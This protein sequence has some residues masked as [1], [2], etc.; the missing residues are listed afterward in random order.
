MNQHKPN[1]AALTMLLMSDPPQRAKC[2]CGAN[3]QWGKHQAAYEAAMD[4]VVK[5]GEKLKENGA[6]TMSHY[7]EA[8]YYMALGLAKMGGSD[9]PPLTIVDG[10]IWKLPDGEFRVWANYGWQTFIKP[11]PMEAEHLPTYIS[12]D[13]VK[14]AEG[15]ESGGG[16][17]GGGAQPEQEPVA[18]ITP[19][20]EGFRMRLEPPTDDVPMGWKALYTA[21]P[22]RDWVGLTDDEVDALGYKYGAGGLELLKEIETKLKEKNK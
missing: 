21:Q 4:H 19:D 17:G 8:S 20:G 10:Q 13:N 15:T 3:P 14:P 5:A 6:K 16:G 2:D 22:K 7:D 11:T 9:T 1:C 12:N 18:W